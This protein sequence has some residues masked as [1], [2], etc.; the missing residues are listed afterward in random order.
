MI[1]G[2][3]SAYK[4]GPLV[5]GAIDSL[6]AGCDRVVVF[7]G[8]AGPEITEDVPASSLAVPAW[9]DR[10]EIRHGRWKTDAEKRTAMLAYCR[11]FTGPTWGVWIDGDEVLCNAEYL[12][13]WLR[14]FDWQDEL[15]AEGEPENMGW[16]IKL[17]E[18]TGDIAVCEAKCLRLDLLDSYSVSSSFYRNTLGGLEK[19]GNRHA[20]LSEF[21]GP[22][23][24]AMEER[25]FLFHWPPLPTE[26]YILHR[27]A[28]RHP[29]RQ[30]NRLHEQEAAEFARLLPAEHAGDGDPLLP[31]EV[32]Q[33]GE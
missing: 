29:L 15:R 21:M 12:A 13:D 2:L 14:V 10:V 26:P 6:L 28:L 31:T 25:D 5:Q 22:Q 4:E 23:L 27:S 17:V 8:P 11:P 24:E 3:C 1:V 30:K 19:R 33:L 20:R 7:E 18:L 16:P 9:T 32:D